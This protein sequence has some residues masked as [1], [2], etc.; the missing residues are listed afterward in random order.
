M[1]VVWNMDLVQS[2]RLFAS[3]HPVLVQLNWPNLKWPTLAECQA[4]LDSL[5]QSP[6]T[7]SGARLRVVHPAS[8]KPEDWRQR[9]EAR[10]YLT[11][12]LQTRAC[13]HD[14]FNLL[15]WATFP[16]AKA[17]LNARHYALLEAR[18][19]S[20]STPRLPQQDTLTQFDES[21]VVIVSADQTLSA[22]LQNFQWKNLFC[23][24]RNE[25]EAQMRCYLFGHGLMEKALTPYRGMTGKG[26]VLSVEPTFF[27][28]TPSQQMAIIDEGLARLIA[29]PER[30]G[31]PN[32]FAP[33]PVLGFPG[34]TSESENPDYY[35][36][37]QYFRPGR[38]KVMNDT[39]K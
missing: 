3:L 23:E 20:P 32:D 18:V 6:T 34:F 19:N 10:I 37:Q 17:A 26:I 1:S 35:E 4:V 21:G 27:A 2:S 31:Q 36:D 11:G 39:L 29:D 30:L 38:Q 7:A 8:G 5:P 9:Y 16:R 33:V 24:R 25:V 12:E 13:W 14:V 15:V 22:L 28:K